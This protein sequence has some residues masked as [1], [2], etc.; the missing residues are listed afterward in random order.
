MLASS[1]L[2]IVLVVTLHL[3]L[4]SIATTSYPDFQLLNVKQTLIGTKTPRPLEP[5]E[6]HE[7]PVHRFHA[8]MQRD[9]KRVASLLLRLSGGGDQDVDAGYEANDFGSDVVSGMDQGNKEYFVRTGIG[10]PPKSQYMVIDSGSD[11]VW[12]QCQPCNQCHR[13]SD[14]VFDLAASASYS[15]VSCSSSV[16]DRVENSGCNARHCR[17]EVMYGDGSYT[18]GTLALET[19][20]FDRTV[21]QSVAIGY[22]HINK[23]WAPMH[24][25]H[26]YSGT[27]HCLGAAWIPLLR[28]PRAPSFYYVGLSRLGFGGTR[29]GEIPLCNKVVECSAGN[30]EGFGVILRKYGCLAAISERL[31]DFTDDNKCIEI[32]GN[33]MTNFHLALADEVLSSIE[34]KNTTKEI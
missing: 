4:S 23:V 26:S 7:V 11:I 12:V 33:V 20:T 6:Y 1:V 9:V 5:P 25:D 31:V 18:K 16:C 2:P 14:P 8:R 34:E 13:Q 21:V 30:H 3:T 10:S 19:L 24:P 32:D 29:D 22:E 27:E 15:G 17:Y 28:N